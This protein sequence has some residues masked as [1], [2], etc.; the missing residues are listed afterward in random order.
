MGKVEFV[1]IGPERIHTPVKVDSCAE[2]ATQSSLLWVIG[3]ALFFL[4]LGIFALQAALLTVRQWHPNWAPVPGAVIP[5][6]GLFWSGLAFLLILRL[7]L[8]FV[9]APQATAIKAQS[10]ALLAAGLL[11]AGKFVLFEIGKLRHRAEME[12]FFRISGYPTWLHYGV[13]VLELIGAAGVLVPVRRIRTAAAAGLLAI[14][15]AAIAT[16]LHNRDPL[17]DTYDALLQALY[18]I[19]FLGLCHPGFRRLPFDANGNRNGLQGPLR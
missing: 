12:N 4:A 18:L 16:H 8:E 11:I 5:L 9:T 17:S 19:L 1:E 6:A 14:M 2:I 13:V 7:R 10:V 3:Y 15:G